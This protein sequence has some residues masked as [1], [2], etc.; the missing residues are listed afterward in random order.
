MASQLPQKQYWLFQVLVR[1]TKAV[2]DYDNGLSEIYWIN[3][4]TE[5]TGIIYT[6]IPE[7][8]PKLELDLEEE[9]RRMH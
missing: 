4:E 5:Q 3:D 2:N 6:E 8:H 1:I 9:R 7:Q